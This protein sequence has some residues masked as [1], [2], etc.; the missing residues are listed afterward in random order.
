MTGTHDTETLAGWWAMAQAD[1][2]QALA[3]L[4][5]HAG[6]GAIDPASDWSPAIHGAILE[7]LEAFAAGR[8]PAD[9]RTL[10]VLQRV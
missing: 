5:G 10:M 2:R 4:L 8:T 9:D 1:E 3:S 7:S 6:F